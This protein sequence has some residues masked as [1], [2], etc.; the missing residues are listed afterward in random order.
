MIFNRTYVGSLLSPHKNSIYQSIETHPCR[1][2]SAPLLTQGNSQTLE[3]RRYHHRSCLLS[4]SPLEKH[5][6]VYQKYS[7]EGPISL[8]LPSESQIPTSKSEQARWTSV[9][10]LS[11]LEKPTKDRQPPVVYFMSLVC[12]CSYITFKNGHLYGDVSSRSGEGTVKFAAYV[13]LSTKTLYVRVH[14]ARQVLNIQI[15]KT[16]TN[17]AHLFLLARQGSNATRQLEFENWDS[18]HRCLSSGE[19]HKIKYRKP[20]T[21]PSI[22][23][24]EATEHECGIDSKFT[25]IC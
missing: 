22:K 15:T 5:I 6:S 1:L 3:P 20:V 19:Q 25:L 18:H 2:M 4:F 10:F 14:V 9:F 21:P 7:E 17:Q 23:I 8:L 16:A 13:Y 11:L 12:R 24:D